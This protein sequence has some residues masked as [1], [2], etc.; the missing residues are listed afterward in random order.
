MYIQPE[1]PFDE[2][3]EFIKACEIQYNITVECV[4]GSV[5]SALVEI[6]KR[7]PSLK[8][9]IMGCRRTDPYCENLSEFQVSFLFYKKLDIENS[10]NREIRLFKNKQDVID[11]TRVNDS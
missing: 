6:C 7:F 9:V 3:E 4:R 2:I 11:K 10:L 1:N 5:K 8:A